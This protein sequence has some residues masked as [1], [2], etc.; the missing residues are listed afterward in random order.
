MK[1]LSETRQWNHSNP[2]VGTGGSRS[3]ARDEAAGAARVELGDIVDNN[4][5]GR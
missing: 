4:V 1:G 3:R 2:A 5:K